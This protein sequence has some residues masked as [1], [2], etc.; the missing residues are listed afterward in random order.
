[1]HCDKIRLTD[2]SR[3][4]ICLLYGQ[5]F[6]TYSMCNMSALVILVL[7]VSVHLGPKVSVQ[8]YSKVKRVLLLNIKQDTVTPYHR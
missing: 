3:Y 7:N 8:S 5:G 6:H 1:M 2:Q 4:S